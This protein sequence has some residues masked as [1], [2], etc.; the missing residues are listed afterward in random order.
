MTRSH[1]YLKRIKTQDLFFSRLL[2]ASTISAA[3]CI[4]LLCWML[5]QE[6]VP[7]TADRSPVAT[8]SFTTECIKHHL[9]PLK[10]HTAKKTYLTSASSF[11]AGLPACTTTP[12]S[13]RN[14]G[15]PEH[16]HSWDKRIYDIS[17]VI[18]CVH[19]NL[20]L[21]EISHK[22]RIE[23]NLSNKMFLS[24]EKQTSFESIL[25]NE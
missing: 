6:N 12:D 2:Q 20:Y 15:A 14:R 8:T 7:S 11:A 18:H 25:R 16:R 10:H 17:T 21:L 22:K 13:L 3:F 5:S 23:Y 4:W 24:A 19:S 9:Y 1:L